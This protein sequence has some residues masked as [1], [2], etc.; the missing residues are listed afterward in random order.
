MR[1]RN[2]SSIEVPEVLELREVPDPVPQAG[3]KGIRSFLR[4]GKSFR[5]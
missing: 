4:R 5:P 3:E 2:S 1:E